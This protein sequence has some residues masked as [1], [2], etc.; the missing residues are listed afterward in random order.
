MDSVTNELAN[1]F[2]FVHEIRCTDCGFSTHWWVDDKS[3]DP[4]KDHFDVCPAKE[5]KAWR[6]AY[7]EAAILWRHPSFVDAE[8]KMIFQESKRKESPAM[9]KE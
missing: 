7:R 1:Y 3:S 5:M 6:D 8:A 9:G 2:R 4:L